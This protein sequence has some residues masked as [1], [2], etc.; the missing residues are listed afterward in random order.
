M[1]RPYF[2]WDYDLSEKDV[3][4]IL[5]EGDEFSRQWLVGRILSHANF[6]DVFKYLAIQEIL[7][8]FPKLKMRKEITQAWE[9]AFVAWG[10]NVKSQKQSS[11][12]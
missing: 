8:I 1:K 12:N 9:R 7:S 5:K 11:F 3:K 2:L 6:K 4:K 10:Y